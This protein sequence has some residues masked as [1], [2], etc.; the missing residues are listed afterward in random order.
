MFLLKLGRK[1]NQNIY[2]GIRGVEGREGEEYREIERV[3]KGC[4]VRVGVEGG[5]V[6]RKSMILLLM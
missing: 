1:K 3:R 6:E 4:M 2:R 5:G